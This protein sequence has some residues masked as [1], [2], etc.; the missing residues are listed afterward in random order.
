MV[1]VESPVMARPKKADEKP[2]K[3]DDMVR[4]IALM[5]RADRAKV[6]RY[7]DHFGVDQEK[8]GAKWILERLALEERKLGW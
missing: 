2:R 1:A 4:F 3:P 6:S 8:L 7:C 5:S